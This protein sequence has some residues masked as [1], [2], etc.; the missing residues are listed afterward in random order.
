MRIQIPGLEP[1]DPAPRFPRPG[2]SLGGTR[3]EP[4]FAI[5][6]PS[7][8]Q[9]KPK[10]REAKPGVLGPAILEPRELA[11]RSERGAGKV[12]KFVDNG[13]RLAGRST[14]Q[15]PDKLVLPDPSDPRRSRHSRSNPSCKEAKHLVPDRKSKAPIDISKALELELE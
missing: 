13:L 9:P 11:R 12:S 6:G 5:F 7:Q 8:D 2:R 10:P 14:R 3:K 15:V 4:L 1:S